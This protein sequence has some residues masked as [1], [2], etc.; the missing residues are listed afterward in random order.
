MTFADLALYDA[1][2]SVYSETDSPRSDLWL[3]EPMC[4][5]IYRAVNARMPRDTLATMDRILS[6][7][8]AFGKSVAVSEGLKKSELIVMVGRAHGR[9]CFYCGR[10]RGP[11]SD[12]V[13]LDRIIPGSRGG[14]Y[15]LENCV[16][17][18]AF[19]NSQRGDSAIEEYL[20][21]VTRT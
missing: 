21:P 5:V 14:Q 18:C 3:R 10:G 7:W 16:I 1:V 20:A 17:A 2:Y 13:A 9:R 8:A 15:T 12:E 6:A 19:H 4:E 11:C